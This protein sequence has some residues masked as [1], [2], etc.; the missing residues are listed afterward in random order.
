MHAKEGLRLQQI[1]EYFLNELESSRLLVELIPQKIRT[2]EGGCI[3][4]AVSKNANWYR[5]FCAAH[6]SSRYRR[7]C[8][9]DTVIRRRQCLSCLHRLSK[10]PAKGVYSE[11]LIS[12]IKNNRKYYEKSLLAAG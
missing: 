10:G 1:A 4:V 5:A 3:R 9:F 12:F 11:R 7:K 6:A 8:A 2:N